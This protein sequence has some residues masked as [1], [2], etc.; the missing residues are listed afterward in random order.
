MKR[1]LFALCVLFCFMAASAA[2]E[3]VELADGGSWMANGGRLAAIRVQSTAASGAFTLKGFES[4]PVSTNV[5]ETVTDTAVVWRRVLTNLTETVTNDYPGQ[6]VYTP[7]PTWRLASEGWVT[8]T[9]TRTV[10]SR[11]RTG[12][13]LTLTNSLAAAS[14]SGGAWTN[15]PSGVYLSDGEVVTFSFS[16]AGAFGRAILIIER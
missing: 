5:T 4:W 6:V 7:P 1:F 3:T 9:S 12:A 10:T 13:T 8:N 15:A 11:R 2:V 16:T 14:C